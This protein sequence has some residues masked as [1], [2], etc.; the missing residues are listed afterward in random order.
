MLERRLAT[1]ESALS[2][3][4]LAE[5]VTGAEAVAADV[6]APSSAPEPG[7]SDPSAY[8]AGQGGGRTRGI[9]GRGR[10]QESKQLQREEADTA[11]SEEVGSAPAVPRG[12]SAPGG[13][14]IRGGGTPPGKASSEPSSH[15]KPEYDTTRKALRHGAHGQEAAMAVGGVQG[16]GWRVDGARQ[17]VTWNHG[18]R[19]PP[20]SRR[21]RAVSATD[22]RDG[23]RHGK[24]DALSAADR[25]L[26]AFAKQNAVSVAELAS[27]PR[28]GSGRV[29][30][31]RKQQNDIPYGRRRRG[32][33]GGDAEVPARQGR[34]GRSINGGSWRGTGSHNDKEAFDYR[35][36]DRQERD[37][38][39]RAV[40]MAQQTE[41]HQ[42]QSLGSSASEI[43]RRL[44]SAAEGNP[45][46]G[47]EGFAAVLSEISAQLAR[48]PADGF[49]QQ[50]V[51]YI[52]RTHG[53][54]DVPI[55]AAQLLF[56]L[57]S[58]GHKESFDRGGF[59]AIFV[60][61]R[62]DGQNGSATTTRSTSRA[63]LP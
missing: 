39:T 9:R 32:R 51:E 55:A 49:S 20:V 14:Q 27:A 24:I 56:R 3:D 6:S 45:M 33:R 46:V 30:A 40:Y 28:A 12:G 47:D 59:T 57:V 4:A 42:Q 60:A 43:Q 31:S 10:Q 16:D 5:Q 53:Q 54:A 1:I 7:A 23:V 8:L 35:G 62:L 15:R 29:T 36:A 58:G 48:H 63:K 19:E 26:Q 41:R 18:S 22:G 38:T 34:N 37:P 25:A 52:A 50:D 13:H 2:V 44:R 61:G 17:V 21:S 11:A